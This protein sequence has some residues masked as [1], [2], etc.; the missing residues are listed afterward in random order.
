MYRIDYDTPADSR[1]F[2]GDT[3]EEAR[4]QA[5]KY[6]SKWRR[7]SRTWVWN[8]DFLQEHFDYEWSI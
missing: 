2:W 7:F 3:Y 8:G 1:C 5:E 4:Q 6:D